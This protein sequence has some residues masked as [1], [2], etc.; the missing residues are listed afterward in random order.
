MRSVGLRTAS[1]F[2]GESWVLLVQRSIEVIE[3][4]GVT[5][6]QRSPAEPLSVSGGILR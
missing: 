6:A 4:A 3:V 2:L 1:G 5:V